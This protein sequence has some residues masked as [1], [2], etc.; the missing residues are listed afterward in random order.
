MAARVKCPRGHW[1]E[2]DPSG[3]PSVCP[4]CK[5]RSVSPDDNPF[6]EDDILSV[7]GPPTQAD[8]VEL[9][10]E[11]PV[12]ERPS[13]KHTLQRHKKVCPACH[14][15]TSVSF[16]HCPR[17]GSQLEIAVIEVL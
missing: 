17:C 16:G 2:P 8:V 3:G 13:P 10:P 11:E 15:E 4:H 12:L 7:L 5:A 6:S 1:F 9:P 14:Y